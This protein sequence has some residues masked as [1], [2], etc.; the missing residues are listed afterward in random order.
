VTA[1]Q[2]QQQLVV[3]VP[4]LYD[5]AFDNRASSFT[6]RSAEEEF[7]SIRLKAS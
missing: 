5:V 2:Q 1:Q 7:L 3:N 4:V 6:E